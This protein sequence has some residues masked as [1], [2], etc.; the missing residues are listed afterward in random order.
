MIKQRVIFLDVDGE[1]TYSSYK[2]NETQN[3]DP[4]KILLVK[5]ICDRTGAK[6]VISS[7]WRMCKNLCDFLI[8]MLTE[9]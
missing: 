5:E 6:V 3:I 2:N 7:S 9:Y 8:N 4:E 1:L